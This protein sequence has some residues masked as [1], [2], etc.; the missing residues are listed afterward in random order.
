MK[1]YGPS[2][3]MG[4]EP[5]GNGTCRIPYVANGITAILGAV[6]LVHDIV[7]YL[8]WVTIVFNEEGF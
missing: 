5:L 7:V 4:I 2:L 3:S 8:A 1:T 6:V